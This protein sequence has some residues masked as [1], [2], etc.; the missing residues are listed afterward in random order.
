[1]LRY[2]KQI[3]NIFDID[4]WFQGHGNKMEFSL[5]YIHHMQSLS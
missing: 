4:L 1:M 5:Q 2:E 3:L